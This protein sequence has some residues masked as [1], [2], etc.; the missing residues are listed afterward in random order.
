MTSLYDSYLL[1]RIRT[2]RD[3]E[4]FARMYDR[5]VGAIYRF[6]L[7]KLPR[8]EDAQDVTAET[9]TRAWQYLNENR[10]VTHLRALFYRI[11]RNLIADFYRTKF[12]HP[13]ISLEIEEK[14]GEEDAVTF[15]SHPSSY[16]V[17]GVYS[18]RGSGKRLLEARVDL[19]LVLQK[20]DR[21]KEDYRDVLLLRLV[22]DLPFAVIADI[23]E[24][25]TGHIRVIFHRGMKMLK[26]LE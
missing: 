23:L 24:K 22:D 10:E 21:L 4:A 26:E 25:N 5:Y 9:F 14:I 17:D 20:L 19:A 3:P 8:E 12:K 6:S 15:G 18:D 7:L 16:S 11:A 13:Q 1:F 2:K